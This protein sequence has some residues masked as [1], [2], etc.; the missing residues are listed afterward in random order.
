MSGVNETLV[1]EC[2][3]ARG[4]LVRHTEVNRNYTKSDTLQIL[5][6][7]KKYDLLKDPALELFRPRR[8][9]GR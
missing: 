8:R 2:F 1:R 6:I 9:G 4:F 5:R 7:L 3:E